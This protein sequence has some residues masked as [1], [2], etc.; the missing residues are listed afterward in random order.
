MFEATNL[1][2]TAGNEWRAGE[3]FDERHQ[4]VHG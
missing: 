2:L 4:T 3:Y 1:V